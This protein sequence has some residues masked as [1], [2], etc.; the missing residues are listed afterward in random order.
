[1]VLMGSNI[2]C[3]MTEE[4]GKSIKRLLDLNELE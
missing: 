3:M 2:R 1:M 4:I